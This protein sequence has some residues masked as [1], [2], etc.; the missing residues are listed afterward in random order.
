MLARLATPAAA[1]PAPA[2]ASGP[3]VAQPPAAQP[4]PDPVVARVSGAEIRLSDIQ[5]AM[6][7]LPDQ[8][9]SMPPQ[10]LYPA[11][12]NQLVDRKAVALLARKEGLDKDPMVQRQMASAEEEALQSALFHRD[13]GPLVTDEAVRSRYDHDIAGK[14]GEP[15][16]HARHILVSSEADAVA[17]IA[18]LKKGGDFAAIAKARS[19]DPGGAQGGDLGWFK[20]GDMLP[21]FAEAAF[22]LQPGQVSDK[23]VHTRYGWHVIQVL[24][25][26]TASPATFEQARDEL[27]N[28]MIQQAVEKLVA[29]AVAGANVERFNLDGTTQRPTDNAEPPPAPPK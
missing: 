11:L 9:R 4:A 17:I 19:T 23:P 22:A 12:I 2:P 26:R 7:G 8:Y 18:D 20:K 5:D 6:Q 29:D 1:Q 10:M 24:E 21:E 16:V 3:P 14:T 15:E 28:Q 13:I 25:R 27:R